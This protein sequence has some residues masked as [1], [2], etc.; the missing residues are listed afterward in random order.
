MKGKP[1]R[2]QTQGGTE[3]GKGP[4]EKAL[5]KWM[6]ENPEEGGHLVGIYVQNAQINTSPTQNKATKSAYEI[7]YEKQTSATAQ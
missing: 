5:E 6:V 3:K 1:Q 2:P 7:Y 4:F